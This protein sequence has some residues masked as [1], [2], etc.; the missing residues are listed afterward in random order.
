VLA[1][2]TLSRRGGTCG[3]TRDA[4]MISWTAHNPYDLAPRLRGVGLFVSV[5]SGHPA[6]STALGN[7]QGQQIE[8]SL[9][10]QSVAFVERLRQLDIPVRFDAYDLGTHDWPYWQWELHRSLPLPLNTLRRPSAG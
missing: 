4:M 9:R 3:A 2:E 6:R 10:L 1:S 8:R 7:Q 5:G